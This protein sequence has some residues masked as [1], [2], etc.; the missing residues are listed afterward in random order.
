[1]YT[2]TRKESKLFLFY[3]N[4]KIILKIIDKNLNEKFIK[5]SP[6]GN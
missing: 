3:K 4:L 6:Y 5:D 1:M 2:S